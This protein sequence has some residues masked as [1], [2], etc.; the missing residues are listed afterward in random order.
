MQ[1]AANSFDQPLADL[2]KRDWLVKL[3]KIVMDHGNFKTLGTR[4]FSAFI[5]GEEDSN[6]LFVSFETFQG[7]RAL[8]ETAQPLGWDLN[9]ALG[10]GHLCIA[11]NHDTWFRDPH[12]FDHFDEM[13]DDGF[14]DSYDK[15]VFYGAGP[16]GY[17]AAAFSV[18]APG[19]TVVMVQPQATLDPRVTE[20]DDRFA[21]KRRIDFSDRYGYAP[22]MLDAA[23]NAFVIYDPAE[24]LD[25]MHAALFTKENVTKLRMRYMGGAIQSD[26]ME[27]QV[28]YRILSKAGTGKLTPQSFASIYRSRR[29]YPP[30]LRRVLSAIDA[31]DRPELAMMLTRNVTARMHAPRFQR[32][33]AQLEAAL[34]KDDA[35]G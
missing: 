20:W 19:S 28:L 27:L 30:Y 9:K 16:C 7:I 24:Q 3:A 22:D 2:S 8:S 4:H 10:W 32:R 14:F 1:D 5:D 17:A 18:A 25:A 15:V 23:Q 12:V 13:S 21:E 6:I 31:Q 26:L 33:L 29:N 35:S 11:S 34:G